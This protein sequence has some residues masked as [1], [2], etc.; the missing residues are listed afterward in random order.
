MAEHAVLHLAFENVSRLAIESIESN[1]LAS[2]TEK[3]TRDQRWSPDDFFVPPELDGHPLRGD[4]V[5]V[6]KLLFNTYGE[7]L[8]PVRRLCDGPGSEAGRR[9]G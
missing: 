4:Y 2:Y 6:C 1:R 3:S 8:E 5:D 7:L 9:I